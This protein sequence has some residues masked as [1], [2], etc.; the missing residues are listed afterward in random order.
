MIAVVSARIT[1]R[2]RHTDRARYFEGPEEEP[3]L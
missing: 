2:K 3:T 1:P